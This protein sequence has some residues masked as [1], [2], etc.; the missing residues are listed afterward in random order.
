MLTKNIFLLHF[1]VFCIFFCYTKVN[2]V[3]WQALAFVVSKQML[4]K[5][6]KIVEKQFPNIIKGG[7]S[8]EYRIAWWI[9]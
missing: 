3:R 1:V 6:H 7:E 8:F 5:N 9:I 2:K 4:V